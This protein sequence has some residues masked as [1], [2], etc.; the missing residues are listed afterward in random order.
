MSSAPTLPLPLLINGINRIPPPSVTVFQIEFAGILPEGKTIPSSW[1]VTCFYDF[2]PNASSSTRRVI[3]VHGIGTSCIGMAPLAL[4]LKAT[5]SL[6]VIYDL[7]GHGLSSTPLTAHVPAIFHTQLLELLS[8][9][10]WS[11]AHILGFSGG[12]TIAATFVAL[13]PQCAKSL[14]LA[15]PAGCL[16]LSDVP[17]LERITVHE[18]WWGLNWLRKRN[19]LG[20]VIDFESKPKPDWKERLQKGDV[21][22]CSCSAV[23]KRTP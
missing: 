14:T 3:L 12:G 7:W 15:T 17:W 8:Y 22:S 18:G 16:K 23:G 6:V 21:E 5:G 13:H 10:K 20:F 4:R 2:S 19:I 11:K 1:G 9:L